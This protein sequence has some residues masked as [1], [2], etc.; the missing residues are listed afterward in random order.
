[1]GKG[2]GSVMIMLGEDE[3]KVPWLGSAGVTADS[4]H[5]ADYQRHW[6]RKEQRDAFHLSKA[7]SVVDMSMDTDNYDQ[8]HPL[9]ALGTLT[10]TRNMTSLPMFN[11]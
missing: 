4:R 6:I 8:S 1:M 7:K 9:M 3:S 5:R 11:A 2:D 10:H